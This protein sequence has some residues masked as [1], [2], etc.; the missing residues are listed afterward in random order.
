M[1]RIIDLQKHCE[2][3]KPCEPTSLHLA[4]PPVHRHGRAAGVGQGTGPTLP[5]G[6][7]SVFS[8]GKAGPRLCSVALPSVCPSRWGASGVCCHL[9]ATTVDGMGPCCCVGCGGEGALPGPGTDGS[10]VSCWHFPEACA[11]VLGR[12]R[13]SWTPQVPPLPRAVPIC[14]RDFP[15]QESH[16]SVCKYGRMS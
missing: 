16:M 6:P 8:V 15:A 1:F 7:H 10:Q 12:G 3:K 9:A 2:R 13:A 5:P 14:K 4:L 11:P